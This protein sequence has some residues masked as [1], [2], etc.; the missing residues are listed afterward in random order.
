MFPRKTVLLLL[1]A[2][3]LVSIIVRY[4]MV[5]HERFETDSYFVHI[6]SNGIV[7]DGQAAWTFS[8]LSYLG[9]FPFSYPSGAPFV[10]A[11]LSILTGLNVDVCI[12]LVN[13]LFAVLFC[14]VAFCLSREFIYRAEFVLLASFLAAMGPRFIDTTYWDGSARGIETVLI[15]LLVFVTFRASVSRNNRLL[16]CSALIG[17]GCFA[18]HHMAVIVVLYGVAYVT[19]VLITTYLPGVFRTRMKRLGA[20]I[21]VSLVLAGVLVALN[22]FGTPGNSFESVGESGF[23]EI[24]NPIMAALVNLG[25]SYTHQV[26]PVLVLAFF[27][28]LAFLGAPRLSIKALFPLILLIALIPVLGSSIYVSMLVAPFA[29]ILGVRWTIKLS[30]SKRIRAK[31]FAV[32]VAVLMVLSLTVAVWSVERWNQLKHTTGD[33]VA[34]DNGVFNDATY[35]NVNGNGI[36]AM[37]NEEV[38]EGELCA[39]SNTRFLQSGPLAAINGDVTGNDIRGNVTFSSTPFPGNLYNWY[40][41]KDE[42]F[43]S[44]FTYY[45]MVAGVGALQNQPSSQFGAYPASHS[46][47]LVVLDNNWPNDYASVHGP[48]HAEF[49]KEVRDSQSSASGHNH[50]A[51]YDI[52]TSQRVTI[53]MVA[54]TLE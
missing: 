13:D 33:T 21:A 3:I 34:V 7:R 6:L 10:F 52:Y 28:V 23:F 11:E 27:G 14:L 31:S 16:V 53:Y 26:G 19:A 41:Y 20:F 37:S 4:P 29:A 30:D 44:R 5:E 15:A 39:Y 40:T 1:F 38:L 32:A 24:N 48:Y 45:L 22:Y 35:L 25:V 54:F 36:F 17:F 12:L 9:Y 47:L 49:L 18:V 46:N 8:P 42:L 43:V 50:F 51:S 2:I